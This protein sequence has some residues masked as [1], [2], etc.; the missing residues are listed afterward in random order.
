MTSSPDLDWIHYKQAY[1]SVIGAS[2]VEKLEDLSLKVARLADTLPILGLLLSALKR[3]R[4][5]FTSLVQEK[6]TTKDLPA[7]TQRYLNAMTAL[8]RSEGALSAM[9]AVAET[10]A[11]DQV[12]ALKLRIQAVIELV[13]NGEERGLIEFPEPGVLDLSSITTALNGKPQQL[14]LPRMVRRPPEKPPAKKPVKK[15]KPKKAS[16]KPIKRKKAGR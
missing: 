1:D 13:Q 7:W 8:A 9:I 15:A 2:D 14:E 3:S 16:K 5:E 12:N 11:S 10:A 6:A 4:Q